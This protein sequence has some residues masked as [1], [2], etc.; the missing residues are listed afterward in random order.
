MT[1]PALPPDLARAAELLQAGQRE[2]AGR[3]LK[4]YLTAHPRDAEGWWLMSQAVSQPGNVRTCLERAL[5]LRPDDDRVRTR[6]AQ[7]D[8]PQE[9]DDSFFQFDTPPAPPAVVSS[10]VSSVPPFSSPFVTPFTS[11]AALPADPATVQVPAR[12]A[13]A[14]RTG[15]S[16]PFDPALDLGVTFDPFAGIEPADDPF[17][18]LR[19]QQPGTG[20]QPEWGPGLS[21]VSEKVPAGPGAAPA[22]PSR[23]SASSSTL[24]GVLVVIFALIALVSVLVLAA[25]QRGWIKGGGLPEMETLDAG[26]FSIE[27]PEAWGGVCKAD[28]QGYTVCGVANDPRYNEVDYFTGA[29]LDF[30]QMLSSAMSGLLSFQE[31]PDLLVSVIAMDVPQNSGRY[32]AS[33]EAK[34]VYEMYT[35]YGLLDGVDYQLDYDESAPQIDGHAASVYRVSLRDTGSSLED[36]V[37][38]G[39]GDSAYYDVYIPHSDKMFWMTVRVTAFNDR[40][41]IPH[42]VI[43]HMI[44][45][46]DLKT[47]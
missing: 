41:E 42:D 18:A 25:R 19:G 14:Y 45:S 1:M 17:A 10:V 9:P 43:E 22:R 7:L 24:I 34:M 26:S 11:S 4:A 13:P 33:S 38:G 8:L 35:E 32:F 21:F 40:E 30:G 37:M 16:A 23:K 27:Y 3:L 44:D 36:F 46:I 28:P 29:E 39:G 12:Q 5:R 2:T 31:S 6:L 20:H 47:S 15:A